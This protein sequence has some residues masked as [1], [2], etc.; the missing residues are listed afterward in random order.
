M[1]PGQVSQQRLPWWDAH[2]FFLLS[3][4]MGLFSR[5]WSRLRSPGPPES[6]LVEAVIRADQEEAKASLAAHHGPKGRHPQGET[7]E[8]RAAEENGETSWGACPDLEAGGSLLE[9]WGLSEAAAEP[10]R[11]KTASVPREQGSDCIGGHAAPLPPKLLIRTLEDPGEEESVEEGALEDKEGSMF[12]FPASPSESCPGVAE[13]IEDGAAVHKE[14]PQTS[15]SSLAPGSKLRAW[16]YCPVEEEGGGTEEGRT[17]D[18]DTTKT[19]ISASAVDSHPRAWECGPGEQCKEKKDEKAEE[20]EADPGPHSS[21]LAPRPLLRSWQHR[22]SESSVEDDEEEEDSVPGAG[23]G[24]TPVPLTSSIVKAWVYRPGE[25]TEEEE[26]NDSGAAEDWGETE[27]L[28]SVPPT[29]A[30]LRAWVYRPGEDTEEEE[31]SDSG[32]AE[33]WGETEGLSSVPP[34]STFLRA[35]VYRPGEDTE[36]E[37][38]DSGAAEDWGETESLSSVPPTSAFLRAWVYRPGEDTEEEEEDSDSGAAEDWG[39]TEGLSSVP[40]T[41][42]FLRAWVYRPGED[43]EEEEEDEDSEAADSEPCPC[44]QAQSVLRGGWP[45]GHG[46]DRE[47]AGAAEEWGGPEPDAFPVAIYLPGEK[48]P[49]P[50]APPR[51]PLR[52]QRRLRPA[53][54]PTQHPEPETPPKARKVR[55]SEK[56][57]VHFLAVWAGPARAARRGPWEQIARDRSRFARRIAQA[58]EELGPCFTPAARASA[59]ARLQNLPSCL[60]DIPVPNQTLPTSTVQ[61]TT[62]SQAVASA[63]PP[64][65]SASPCLN[66]SGRRG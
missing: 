22:P 45:H 21:L 54:T 65:M 34:T 36:E 57:S 43:T 59:W 41:S 62:L 29:S 16:V 18:K 66:L 19:A 51:L 33:D 58:E 31:D 8:I 12:S 60:T 25:D 37:D 44:L 35:W 64:C 15:T 23:R 53:E 49:P 38:S 52:L 1:A 63:S 5:A 20:E 50:P 48:P 17:E 27:S 40:P 4:L 11:G 56:V 39:E 13:D 30:F 32:A 55:F 28:S 3:P 47:G 42:A 2:P 10:G 46:E 26:D 9:T 24:L 61:A 7:G 6:W 14:A